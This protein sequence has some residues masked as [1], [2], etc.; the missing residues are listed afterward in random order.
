M[1]NDYFNFAVGSRL[2]RDTTARSADVNALIDSIEA[3]FNVL[4]AT[5]AIHEGKVTY[6]GDDTGTV[7]TYLVTMPSTITSYTDGLSVEFKPLSTNTGAATL[8][9]SSVGVKPLLRADGSAVAAG[10]IIAN[11]ILSL[12]YSDNII[13]NGAFIIQHSLPS[14]ATAAAASAASAAADVVLSHA[15]VVLTHADVVLTHADVALT[16]ADVVLTHADVVLTGLDVI[17]TNTNAATTGGNVTTTNTNVGLT[18]A[19]VVL[20]HADVVLTHADVALTNADVL[21]TGVDVGL[22]N[23]DVVLTHADVVLTHADVVTVAGIYDAFDDRYLGAK[24]ANPTLDNDGNALLTGALYWNTVSSEMRV[25]SG[26]AWVVAYLPSGTYVAGPASSVDGELALFDSTTGKLVKRA[27]TTGMLKATSGVVGAATAGTDYVAPGTA[28]NFT[29]PQRPS[30]SAEITPAANAV[31]LDLTTYNIFP[32]NLNASITTMNLT[33]TLAS[34]IGN[35]YRV[36]IRY[37]GGTVVTFNANVKFPAGT[38]PTLTGTSG[39][40]DSFTFEVMSN[41]GGTTCY[42]YEVGRNL[43]M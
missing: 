22:T 27:T 29:K 28:T 20:T 35:Q 23:A 33:G 42:L 34:L 9:V 2:V 43:N 8:N 30:L 17:T 10:D 4:P 12:R 39:K 15:D 3:G 36:D 5:V 37:N 24:A 7:N 18:N 41:D 16:H 25:Y 32:I 13:T 1:A 11:S 14:I 40:I 38:A 19:D 21:S 26:A 6:C 31:T